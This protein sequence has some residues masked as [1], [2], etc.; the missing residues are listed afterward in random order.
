MQKQ[1]WKNF[2]KPPDKI[3]AIAELNEKQDLQWFDFPKG[4]TF[5]GVNFRTSEIS[6]LFQLNED[7]SPEKSILVRM[8][9]LEPTR[10]KAPDPKTGDKTSLHGTRANCVQTLFNKKGF[11]FRNPC[12]YLL[13]LLD[14]NLLI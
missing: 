2:L 7:S 11:R 13:P 3:W 4:L 12:C 8:I 6:S 5:D 9:R 1:V 14:L 10:S